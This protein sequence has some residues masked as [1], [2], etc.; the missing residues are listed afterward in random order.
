VP[1][2]KGWHPGIGTSRLGLPQD[3]RARPS[4]ALD[5]RLIRNNKKERTTKSM[6]TD[7][8]VFRQ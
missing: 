4:P 8:K 2:F 5:K 3:H 6:I 7:Q 1:P